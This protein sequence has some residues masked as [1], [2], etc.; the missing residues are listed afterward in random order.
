MPYSDAAGVMVGVY[1]PVGPTSHD[2]I[3]SIRKVTGIRKVGHAGTLDPL[4][5]G[6][7]VVGIGRPAT[8]RL[9]IEVAKEKEYVASVLLGKTSSTGDAEGDLKERSIDSRPAREMVDR[10]LSTFEGDVEQ[11][12]PQYSA[13][14][15]DGK[16]AYRYAREGKEVSMPA[17]SVVIHSIELLNYSWPV[18]TIRV[19]C[20]PGTYIRTLAADVGEALGVGGYLSALQRTRVGEYTMERAIRIKD[21]ETWWVKQLSD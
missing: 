17:R 13:I 18:L 8:K 6:V 5:E 10:T 2:V 16:A 15:I 1:K 4:A 3:D 7:L 14:K 11:I 19:V 20:G 12:P 9:S 21:L